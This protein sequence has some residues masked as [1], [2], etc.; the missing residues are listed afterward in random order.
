[1]LLAYVALAWL[2]GIW[3]ASQFSA[4]TTT[5]WLLICAGGV[6]AGWINRHV[7]D[8]RLLFALVAVMALG[9]VRMSLE[10]RSS[11]LA[12]YNGRGGVQIE[13]AVI[14]PPDRR[15]ASVRLRVQAQTVNVSGV[16]VPTSGI[17]LVDAP[18]TASVAYGDLVRVSGRLRAP[19]AFDRFDYADFLGRQGVFS[20]MDR[21][22]EVEVVTTGGGSPVVHAVSG[23]RDRIGALFTSLL[24]EPHA[25]IL[26]AVVTGNEQYIAPST[27]SA[28]ADSGLS[29][30]LAVSGFNMTLVAGFA[31][32]WIRRAQRPLVPALFGVGALIVYLALVGFAASAA[33]AALMA[34]L[35]LIG[36]AL[37]RQSNLVVSLGFAAVVLTALAPRTLFDVGF[38]LS[39]A[40]MLGIAVIQP[41]LDRAVEPF[42]LPE[43]P[44]TLS[45][46]V[47]R[48]FAAAGTVTISASVLTLPISASVFGTF[49][50]ATL[51]TNLLVVPLQSIILI[52][53]FV[54]IVVGALPILGTFV[55][56]ALL[57]PLAWMTT[58]AERSAA[59]QT[60][61]E[62]SVHPVIP[63]ILV[64]AAVTSSLVTAT[65]PGWLDRLRGRRVLLTGLAALGIVLGLTGA[66]I[67]GQPD[68]NLH[69]WVLDV[70]HSHAVFI[71]SPNG[72]QVLVDGGRYPSRLLTALGQRMAFYDRHIDAVIVTHPDPFDISALPAVLRRYDVD[73]VLYHGQFNAGAEL[74]EITA[75]HPPQTIEAGRM[76][77][78]GD[79]A[80]I[81]VLHPAS[82]PA[83]DD[84]IADVAMVLRV[85]YGDMSFLL[86]SDANAAAQRDLLAAGEWPLA[87]VM[88]LPMH[89]GARGLDADFLDA[90]QP[91]VVALQSDRANVLGDPDP[92]VLRLLPDV[93]FFRTDLQGTLHFYTNGTDLYVET[94]R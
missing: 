73:H 61:L 93:P 79:G 35:V 37:R 90:V 1:M 9:A 26:T 12:A 81:E 63:L 18:S 2:A 65:R 54:L 31:L 45:L 80:Y 24:P 51:L 70:G 50:A 48:M 6:L 57:V 47:V 36:H 89:G 13:G 38:Q 28:Y 83:A 56:S 62:V 16:P 64:G 5:F 66:V 49:P 55:A 23:L 74:A 30:L 40:A 25:G 41:R 52:G 14:E 39:F 29:H 7:R 11:A 27:R 84:G 69:V 67:S 32:A 88:L 20:L 72:A 33:R 46:S 43:R 75:I 87:T 82:V 59:A 94:E 42:T 92:D 91:R 60:S 8:W 15:D 71:Q 58:V 19:Q 85:T 76:I 44:A 77:D 4:L 86:P 22:S 3:A 68:G 34:A 17:V 10:P 78:L 21:V 53:G